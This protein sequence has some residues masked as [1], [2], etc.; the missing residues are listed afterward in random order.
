MEDP[1]SRLAY[2]NS[3]TDMAGEMTSKTSTVQKATTK[4]KGKAVKRP[5][6]GKRPEQSAADD[7]DEDSD[8][9]TDTDSPEGSDR[10]D[11][12]N[13]NAVEGRWEYRHSH[14]PH[15]APRLTYVDSWTGKPITTKKGP[16]HYS[17][18]PFDPSNAV[19]TNEILV[20]AGNGSSGSPLPSNSEP[21]SEPA[22]SQPADTHVHPSDALPTKIP[23]S[24]GEGR[25]KSAQPS[26]E[27][28]SDLPPTERERSSSALPS[29]QPAPT[30]HSEP[31]DSTQVVSPPVSRRV[32]NAICSLTQ[33][34]QSDGISESTM[35][36]V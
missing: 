3:D 22:S 4:E 12:V 29:S 1:H 5:A 8:T 2:P 30:H 13:G 18:R 21:T 20:P 6:R 10:D 16:S 31:L 17:F 32:D 27:H 36:R 25:S 24:D 33:D 35:I 19:H 28:P 26:S 11:D 9:T 7:D 14:L 34:S 23:T 15:S